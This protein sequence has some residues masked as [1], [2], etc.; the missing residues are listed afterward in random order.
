MPLSTAMVEWN[1]VRLLGSQISPGAT[2][3]R[4]IFSSQ[5]ED[6]APHLRPPGLPCVRR[7]L[8]AGPAHRGPAQRCR[9]H[10]RVPSHAGAPLAINE[11]CTSAT[12]SL[13][14]PVLL[15][16]ASAWLFRVHPASVPPMAPPLCLHAR[17]A[18]PV[19]TTPLSTTPLS[20]T[21]SLPHLFLHLY[22]SPPRA[23]RVPPARLRAPP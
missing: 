1:K 3:P 13:R 10:R 17:C 19:S 4:C 16:C 9:R 6:H 8:S 12:L 15:P 2:K 22:C 21:L 5:G 14:R 18:A 11:N 20:V 7:R 23:L